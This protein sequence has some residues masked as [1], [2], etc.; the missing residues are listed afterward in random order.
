MKKLLL[1]AAAA[2]LCSGCAAPRYLAKVNGEEITGA[3]MRREFGKRHRSMERYLATEP[4]VRKVLSSV[5]DRK[6]FL[7]EARRAGLQ[8]D[9]ALLEVIQGE[10]ERKLVETLV[11]REVDDPAQPTEAEVA[12]AYKLMEQGGL[13]R[14]VVTATRAE[15]EEVRTRA[16][17]GD[18]FEALARERS[19]A[20]SRLNGGLLAL[21]FGDAE[22]ARE[23]AG[24]ALR[25]GDIS[26]VFEMRQG[27]AVL[28]LEE[29][30]IVVPPDLAVV[31]AKIS[32]ILK[33]RKVEVLDRQLIAALRAKYSAQVAPCDFSLASLEKARTTTVETVCAT[34]TGG[35]YTLS[36][37]A[38]RLPLD[39]LRAAPPER[40]DAEVELR[41]GDAV[42]ERLLLA[43]AI[44]RGLEKD[45][46]VVE[47]VQALEEKLLVE[48]Y[49][50]RYVTL[51]VTVSDAEVEAAYKAQKAELV[52]PESR[53]IAQIEVASA[54]AA[55]AAQQRLGEG[56][57]F[58]AV[59]GELSTNVEQAQRGGVVGWKTRKEVSDT[60]AS[61]FAAR[62]G[63][64]VGPIAAGG[65]FYLVK[66]MEIRPETP[67]ERTEAEAKVRETLLT[68]RRFERFERFLDQLRRESEIEVSDAGIKRYLEENP[69]PAVTPPPAP[70]A[71]QGGHAGM[72]S[73]PGD[74]PPVGMPGGM[75]G[76]HGGPPPGGMPGGHGGPPPGAKSPTPGATP[77]AAT[78]PGAAPPGPATPRPSTP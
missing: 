72:G 70:S 24:R 10:R 52:V 71:G 75:P 66:V 56:E 39:R 55:A 42:A 1:I 33:R 9:P 31:Q 11:R 17:A 23:E 13:A 2:G 58:D 35:S 61:V 54:E 14:E 7:Q 77:P 50:E 30:K 63:A 78:S 28:K 22:V 59:A 67:L 40:Y 60:F 69:A 36:Q 12:A 47:P 44:A 16:L 41:V 5:I 37:L 19:I 4:E 34:W 32:A 27:W 64:V 53:L 76:G 65:R 73:M 43:E 6:L 15:A 48:L 26:P 51:E 20:R 57:R 74:L 68:A 29:R 8:D 45:P 38:A 3:D 49:L 62:Q 46:E 21:R 18:D 25:E